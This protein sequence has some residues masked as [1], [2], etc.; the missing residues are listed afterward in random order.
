VIVYPKNWREVGTEI[1]VEAVEDALEDA[2]HTFN[3]TNLALSGGLDSSLL[4]YY[5]CQVFKRIEV[6]TIG[7]TNEHP[8]IV[9]AK[10]VVDYFRMRYNNVDIIH[11]IC[12]PQD[13]EIKDSIEEYPG[14]R[15]VELFYRFVDKYTDTIVA[16]DGIDEFMC[17]YYAHMRNP[18]E[19][20]YYSYLRKLQKEQLVPL[21]L[22]SGNV[23]V[24]LPYLDEKVLALLLQIPLEDKVDTVT[25]KKFLIKMAL[26]KVPDEAITRRK[27]GF[28]DAFVEKE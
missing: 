12:Y 11:H 25:R 27:Y 5:M 8:D 18:N 14:D 10:K 23:D 17:G 4:L 1:T 26:G 9:F 16:G 13:W 3:C 7:K 28:C 6:F 20:T 22:N 24:Y 21:D 15:A 2:F 19:E